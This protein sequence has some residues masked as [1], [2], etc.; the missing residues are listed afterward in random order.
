MQ[1]LNNSQRSALEMRKMIIENLVKM[2]DGDVFA[3]MF[4]AILTKEHKSRANYCNMIDIRLAI[5]LNNQA[6]D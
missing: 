3:G 5:N 2:N 1:M 6:C 4:V